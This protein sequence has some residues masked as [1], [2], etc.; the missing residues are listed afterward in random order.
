MKIGW[1]SINNMP[2]AQYGGNSEK[3]SMNLAFC[4][5][6]NRQSDFV[7]LWRMKEIWNQADPKKSKIFWQIQFGTPFVHY[8]RSLKIQTIRVWWGVQGSLNH[9]SFHQRSLLPQCCG[10]KKKSKEEMGGKVRASTPS[11]ALMARYV[12]NWF[13]SQLPVHFVLLREGCILLSSR[14]SQPTLRR[15]HEEYTHSPSSR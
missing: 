15:L 12:L 7:I 6:M 1:N 4:S 9:Y 2:S 8:A 10:Q 5:T 11:D 14:I 3:C 13:V